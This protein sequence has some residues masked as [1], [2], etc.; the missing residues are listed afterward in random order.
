MK[1][2]GNGTEVEV[3]VC[4]RDTSNVYEIQKALLLRWVVQNT[5]LKSLN[6]TL[7]Y[8]VYDSCRSY[9]VTASVSVRIAGNDKIIGVSG[10]DIKDLMVRSAAVTANMGFPTFTYMSHDK[11]LADKQLYKVCNVYLFRLYFHS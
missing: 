3:E 10:V 5:D 8:V 11:D 6:K 1:D 2:I 4:S 7:G 9:H